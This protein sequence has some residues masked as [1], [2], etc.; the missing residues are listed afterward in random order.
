MRVSPVS[1]KSYNASAPKAK[2][3]TSTQN[4]LQANATPSFK[5]L[6]IR[7]KVGN[8]QDILGYLQSIP[9]FP[10]PIF[11]KPY[12]LTIKS[13]LV[14]VDDLIRKAPA[15]ETSVHR[16]YMVAANDLIDVA[17]YQAK[18]GLDLRIGA[19]DSLL[20]SHDYSARHG[21]TGINN[22]FI[23]ATNLRDPNQRA[24]MNNAAIAFR[25]QT[26]QKI[27]PQLTAEPRQVFVAD[28]QLRFLDEAKGTPSKIYWAYKGS[29]GEARFAD[30]TLIISA[31]TDVEDDIARLLEAEHK[32]NLI[33][34]HYPYNPGRGTASYWQG[35]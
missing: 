4:N 25:L 29:D 13:G 23:D 33:Y 7:L 14:P 26:S 11:C 16:S 9:I 24:I 27:I 31:A 1:Y 20:D 15:L 35:A 28:G 30:D 18:D 32:N 6:A 2:S 22:P 19:I 3:V 21:R 34:R 8:V 17:E 5:G 12:K 10:R